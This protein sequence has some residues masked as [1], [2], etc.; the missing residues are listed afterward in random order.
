MGKCGES[1]V[2]IHGPFLVCESTGLFSKLWSSEQTQRP[3]APSPA[4]HRRNG[5]YDASAGFPT[6]LGIASAALVCSSRQ[7]SMARVSVGGCDAP[8]MRALDRLFT[9]HVARSSKYGPGPSLASE[10]TAGEDWENSGSSLFP[11]GSCLCVAVEMSIGM[12]E[13]TCWY[14][15]YK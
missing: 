10:P 4:F 6:R 1:I 15:A 8:Q 13:A 9:N 7:G 14:V 11:A 3:D 5:H 2:Y 12:E